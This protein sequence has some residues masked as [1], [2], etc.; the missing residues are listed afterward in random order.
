[1]CVH[2]VMAMTW[3]VGMSVGMSVGMTCKGVLI[4]T[5]NIY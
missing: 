2:A 3:A 1:M 5:E 4:V